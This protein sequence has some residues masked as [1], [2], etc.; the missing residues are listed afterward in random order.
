MGIIFL[1]SE[2]MNFITEAGL[3]F[4]NKTRIL[5]GEII[6]SKYLRKLSA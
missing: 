4:Q 6:K 5:D 2:Q 1:R 3:V